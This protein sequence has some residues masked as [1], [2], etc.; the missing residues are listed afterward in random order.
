MAD[1]GSVELSILSRYRR[2]DVLQ[3][4]AQSEL[5]FDTWVPPEILRRSEPTIHVVTEEEVGRPDLIAFRV[6]GDSD[7]FW[8]I[9]IQNENQIFNPLRDMVVGQRLTVPHKDDVI[10]ALL[11]R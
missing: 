8:A 10:A 6:Y 11:A 2:T 7:M 3:E 9:A 5:F 1:T 4:S